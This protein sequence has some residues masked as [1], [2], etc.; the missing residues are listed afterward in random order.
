M[1]VLQYICQN[2]KYE[3]I[4]SEQQLTGGIPL[5]R[6]KLG[7]ILIEHGLITEAQLGYALGNSTGGRLGET[8]VSLGYT[9]PDKIAEAIAKQFNLPYL[10]LREIHF[11]PDAVKLLNSRTAYRYRVVPISVQDGKLQL[12][13][14]D[15]L[16]VMALDDIALMTGLSIKVVVMTF[17]DVERALAR[18]YPENRAA[19]KILEGPQTTTVAPVV[20]TV[21]N[22]IAQALEERASDIHLEPT[23]EGMRVRFRIDG[24]L[25]HITQLPKDMVQ[26]V[27]SRLKITAGLDIAERRLPQ[28]GSIRYTEGKEPLDMRVSTLP[29]ILGE[30]MVLRLLR[31]GASRLSLSDIGLT[32]EMRSTV[33]DILK[34]SYGMFLVTGP[35]GSGK[36]TTLY[37]ALTVLEG[38]G[39]NI[40]TV[41]DPVEFQLP[42]MNQ[43]QVQPRIGLTFASVLRALV[44]QDPNIIMV[45]EIRDAETA[46]IAIRSALTGHLV[47]SSLHTND[48]PSTISRLLDMDIEPFLIASAVVGI[49]AQRLV[50]RLCSHCRQQVTYPPFSPVL[51]GLGVRNET[52]E[53]YYNAVGCNKCGDEGYRGRVGIFEVLR[54]DESMGDLITSGASGKVLRDAAR[55]RGWRSFR[56]DGLDK[57]RAGITTIEEV[58]R[59]AYHEE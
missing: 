33:E 11:E 48:A 29:T 7:E 58:L 38:P 59:V 14:S 32:A 12:G 18:L 21:E 20:R 25:V 40:V 9:S 56:H 39:K 41:E 10:T 23:E 42:G 55:A 31:K 54:V 4:T 37:S 52:E 35:T 8:L 36:T 44:R 17:S 57:A 15:P 30:K 2:Y 28:D 3:T 43:V 24:I 34:A 1:Q 45:G 19:T 47:L 49:L 16:N 22:L 53:V 26:P 46:D 13:S 6:K 5:K 50:R 27:I 51:L